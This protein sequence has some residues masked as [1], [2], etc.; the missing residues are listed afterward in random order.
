MDPTK[1]QIVLESLGQH[2]ANYYGSK[3]DTTIL[4]VEEGGN[5]YHF[6]SARTLVD[7]SR[8]KSGCDNAT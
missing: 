3:Q 6:Q 5:F 7:H 2:F 1:L 8:F 4:P